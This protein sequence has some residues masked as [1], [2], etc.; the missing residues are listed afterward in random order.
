[1]NEKNYL[2]YLK[3]RWKN[4]ILATVRQCNGIDYLELKDKIGWDEKTSLLRKLVDTLV[5]S[6]DLSYDQTLLIQCPSNKTMRD[7]NISD[8]DLVRAYPDFF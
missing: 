6:K 4:R 8:R 2:E 7:T 5:R 1:M 3:D